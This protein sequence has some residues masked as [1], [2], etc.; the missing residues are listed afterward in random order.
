MVILTETENFIL[1]AKPSANKIVKI[2]KG[3]YFEIVA[4]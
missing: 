3:E 4:F 2:I 1:L